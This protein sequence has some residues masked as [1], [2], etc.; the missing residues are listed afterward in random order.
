ML[1][2]RKSSSTQGTKSLYL[3]HPIS[4]CLDI[5]QISHP[6]HTWILPTNNRS[7]YHNKHLML[8]KSNLKS[9]LCVR[10]LCHKEFVF[11]AIISKTI[12]LEELYQ[13]Y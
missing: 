1:F 9:Y 7:F 8:P 3:F 2:L 10:T 5:H 12:Y 11:V 6:F 13:I 4:L